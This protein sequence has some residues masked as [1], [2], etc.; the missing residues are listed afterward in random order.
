MSNITSVTL[1]GSGVLG[2]QIAWHS[3]FKGKTVVVYDVAEDALERCRAAHEQYASIYESTLEASPSDLAETRARLS[4]TSDLAS[5]VASADLVIEAVPEIPDVKTAVY[6]S[7]AS[8]LP[9]HTIVATNTSTLL[10]STFAEATGRPSQFCALHFGN[11]I[12]AMNFAEI[13]AHAGTSHDTLLQITE[14]AIEIGMMPIPVRK[15]QNGYVG[16][17]WFVP[18]L[19]A[20]QSLVTNGVAT[21][22]DVDRSYMKAGA[23]AGPMAMFD[24]VGMKTAHDVLTYWGEVNDDDQMRRNADYVKE[25]FLDKGLLGAAVGQGYYSWPTPSFMAPDFLDVP[26][27]SKA[28]EIASLLKPN[29]NTSVQTSTQ[30]SETS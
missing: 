27:I 2:S 30:N 11:G 8:L 18:L 17:S 10:P 28:P 7:M 14:Y 26:D 19:N 22:E 25:N 12:W 5:A 4:F 9:E 1:L 16:N 6:R 21:Y 29:N 23:S 15:E 13:M 3:A 24:Q 20:A